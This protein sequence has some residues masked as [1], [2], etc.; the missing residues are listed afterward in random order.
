[1]IWRDHSYLTVAARDENDEVT[2]TADY[3]YDHDDEDGFQR[4]VMARRRNLA[5]KVHAKKIRHAR[6]KI[7]LFRQGKLT[8]AQLPALARRIVVKGRRAAESLG[9]TAKEKP[10][11]EPAAA[12]RAEKPKAPPAASPP[13]T[14]PPAT[15]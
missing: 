12:E 15:A 9:F 13:P 5:K 4:R 6:E 11:A 3:E 14:S 7:A 1:V 8:W 2:A 10:K